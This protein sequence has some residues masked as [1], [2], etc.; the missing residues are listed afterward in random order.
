[1]KNQKSLGKW[2]L[3]GENIRPE[4]WFDPLDEETKTAELATSLGSST[5]E[6]YSGQY[7]CFLSSYSTYSNVPIR[8]Y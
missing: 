3:E 5:F 4:I 6:Q 2:Y 7:L 1:M 8:A